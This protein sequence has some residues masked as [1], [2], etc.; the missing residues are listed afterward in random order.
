M[1]LP[2]A[3]LLRAAVPRLAL[4]EGLHQACRVLVQQPAQPDRKMGIKLIKQLIFTQNTTK[5]LRKQTRKMR[6]YKT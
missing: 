1:Y 2:L 4:H 5:L 6:L 3:H